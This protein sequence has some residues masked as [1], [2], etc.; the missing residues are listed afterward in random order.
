MKM[1]QII[2]AIPALG[3]LAEGDMRMTDAYRLQKL[4]SSLQTEIDFFNGQKMK[5]ALK[6]GIENADGSVEIP[7]ENEAEA[8]SEL[9]E[10]MAV[11]VKTEFDVIR[12]PINDNIELSANDIGFLSP[13]VEFYSA[14]GGIF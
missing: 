5:L 11:E 7:K 10:L 9:D 6:H 2:H 3:K 8:Q 14:E 4:L 1:Y 12:I 13:F